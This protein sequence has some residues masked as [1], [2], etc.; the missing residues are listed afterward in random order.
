MLSYAVAK[1]RPHSTN[2]GTLAIAQ[3]DGGNSVGLQF[4]NGAGSSNW[5]MS[6]QPFGGNVGINKVNPSGALHVYSGT[7]ERFLVSGD[8]HV[9]GSTD[10]NINGTFRR[11]SFTSG[12]G[13][14][15]TTTAN[16][17][18]LQTNSTT[19]LTIDTNQNV[20]IV[21]TLSASGYNKTSWDT[22]YGWGDHSQV[23]YITGFTNT[24]EFV[25]GATF[26]SG[27]GIVTFT[28]NNGG[29]T[30]TVD[31]D[32]RYSELNHNHDTQYLE[33]SYG[34]VDMDTYD[35]DKSLLLG[36]NLGGWSSGTKPSG[37]HNGFGI[38]HVTTHVGGYATQFGFDTNQN[39]IWV[40]SKNPT[41]WG[42]W[43][44]MWTEQDFT[45]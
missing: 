44:Y 36:R 30:Y 25:T 24:N 28:R 21:G 12:T 26:N 4:T 15:R 7:S 40:R 2:S 29:D 9:Q 13:T 22:A 18:L 27:N 17:L 19:A 3:V 41:S 6:L 16:N 39:K 14:I 20:S 31:L 42:S 35:G 5:D 38:L 33:N 8:V 43:K 1:F 45:Y 34:D 11:L 32:G 37:T 23:G 10:L